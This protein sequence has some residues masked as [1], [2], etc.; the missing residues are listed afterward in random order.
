M[1]DV[2]MNVQGVEIERRCSRSVLPRL[3]AWGS[4]GLVAGGVAGT[5]AATAVT[6]PVHFAAVA[7]AGLV[8]AAL[9]A[10]RFVREQTVPARRALARPGRGL[11]VLGLIAFCAFLID[12][13]AYQ[14]SAAQLSTD[15][16][17]GPALAAAG[18]TVFALG[19]AAGRLAAGRLL[20]RHGPRRTVQAA[21]LVW[22]P[23]PSSPRCRRRPRSA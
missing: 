19:L 22:S 2:A 5:L 15:K 6:V 20:D 4:L 8:L 13:T 17:A 7:G 3:H 9:A 12:G 14:W 16:D 11:A 1:L 10:R 21:G 18:F 23:G